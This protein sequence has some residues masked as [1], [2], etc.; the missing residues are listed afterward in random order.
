MTSSP[1]TWLLLGAAGRIGAATAE[2]LVGDETLGSDRF[3][4]VDRDT[5]SGAALVGR[6]GER[7][8]SRPVP[9]AAGQWSELLAG[10]FAVLDA[11]AVPVDERRTAAEAALTAGA[12]WLDLGEER[13]ALEGLAAL[14]EPAREAG[15]HARTAAGLHCAATAPFAAKLADG[16]VR[17]NEVLIGLLRDPAQ[18]G[19]GSLAAWLQR[20]ADR[21]KLLLGG[22]WSEREAYGDRRRFPHPPPNDDVF[23]ENFDVPEHELLTARPCKATS[24]RVSLSMPTGLERGAL[25]KAGRR[26]AGGTKPADRAAGGL[27][28]LARWFGRGKRSTVATILVRGIDPDR[29]PRERRLSLCAPPGSVALD[30][31]PFAACARALAAGGGEPGAGAAGGLLDADRLEAALRAAGVSVTHGDLAGWRPSA[32]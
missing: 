19:P 11:R 10:V 18:T 4:L 20:F 25:H 1:R 17:T 23:A 31:V 6:L 7:T 28:R 29:L 12:H 32:S 15:L 8:E 2:L 27:V 14:D 24:V 16:L 21:P 13:G 26:V 3:L 30:A 22:E 9:T 5:E